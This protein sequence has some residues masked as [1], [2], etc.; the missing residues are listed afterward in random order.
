M[1]PSRWIKA[2]WKAFA[3]RFRDIARLGTE[4]FGLT[5]SIHPHAAGFIDFEPEVERLLD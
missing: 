2:E 1:R 3:G 5:V 4:E